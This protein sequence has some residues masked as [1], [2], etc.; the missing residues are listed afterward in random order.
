MLIF[1][2]V[3]VKKSFD[4]SDIERKGMTD[5][6]PPSRLWKGQDFMLR[7]LLFGRQVY[8]KYSMDEMS[9]YAAQA[10][11]FIIMAAF[12]FFMVLLALIQVAPMIHEADLLR[13]LLPAIPGRF[14]GLLIYLLDSLHSD[15]PAALISVTALA[16]VWSA[17]KGM[18]G[19]EKG[20]N[21]VFGVTSPRNYILRRALCSVYTLAFSLM[22]VTSLALLVFG[23]FLQEMLLKWFPALSYL[24]GMISLGRGLVMFIML[25]IFFT[26]I[27]TALPHRR[28]SICGQIPG[29][30]FSAA[31]WALTSLAFSVYFRYFGT[32]AVTYGSLT[33]VILFMLWLYVSI[34]ILFVGAEINWFLLFYKEKIMSI[35]ENGL[36]PRPRSADD[37]ILS[38]RGNQL[39]GPCESP[40]AFCTP[41]R[42]HR[43]ARTPHPS[44]TSCCIRDRV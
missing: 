19:I 10:S 7:L 32:Y 1:Y 23:S 34:C 21:R 44:H 15:S 33:A 41:L 26:A 4:L 9:V 16:A 29:A 37:C 43:A 6:I 14:Q 40:Q 3:E 27:Y 5:R 25:M 11:F 38:R 24:S 31:G 36:P 28:L 2:D 12:P 20:L 17:A 18:L 35:K 30:M 39:S 13:F 22:C 8:L 42:D